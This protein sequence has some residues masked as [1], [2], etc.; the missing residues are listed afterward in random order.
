MKKGCSCFGQNRPKSSVRADF[1]NAGIGNRNRVR[2]FRSSTGAG[3]GTSGLD[4]HPDLRIQA[5]GIRTTIRCCT[6][7]QPRP[8]LRITRRSRMLRRTLTRWALLALTWEDWWICWTKARIPTTL[9]WLFQ[10]WET[11]ISSL[12]I[13]LLSELIGFG[14]H[15]WSSSFFKV[16]PTTVTT[17]TTATTTTTTTLVTTAT[18]IKPSKQ[19]VLINSLEGCTGYTDHTM[20][21]F[22]VIFDELGPKIAKSRLSQ[23]T[24]SSKPRG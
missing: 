12:F 22:N 21:H 2:H 3:T 13:L 7:R 5:T 4:T 10:S 11:G 1:S 19:D 18:P 16:D 23:T 15:P 6:F 17:T 24:R 20:Q 8:T 9:T 14:T